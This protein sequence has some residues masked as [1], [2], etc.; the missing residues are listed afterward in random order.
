MTSLVSTF[1]LC[2]FLGIII[3][4]NFFVF[5]YVYL[6]T[7]TFPEQTLVTTLATLF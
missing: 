1:N 4:Q 6:W 7:G 5:T 2:D 3:C